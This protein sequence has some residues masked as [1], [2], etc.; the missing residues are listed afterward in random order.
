MKRARCSQS[1]STHTRAPD[2]AWQHHPFL[3]QGATQSRMLPARN[4]ASRGQ[5]T[6]WHPAP[7]QPHSVPSP[8][9]WPLH[10]PPSR[11]RTA[12]WHAGRHD[13]PFEARWRLAAG[14][15]WRQQLP[16]AP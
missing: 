15:H 6:H 10:I 14:P 3:N 5:P 9:H 2:R 4:P 16:Q 7:A 8:G 13:A 1:I 11:H 12:R